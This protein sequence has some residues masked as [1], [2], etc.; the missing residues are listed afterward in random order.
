[1]F[2]GLFIN[3]HINSQ[4]KTPSTMTKNWVLT[5]YYEEDYEMEGF[6]IKDQ[7]EHEAKQ[8]VKDFVETNQEIIDYWTLD[9]V[10]STKANKY[11]P[12]L[13]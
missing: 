4:T 1:M 3:L 10:S 8:K 11:P 9:E 7:T 13:L 12:L 2:G 6:S 5:V